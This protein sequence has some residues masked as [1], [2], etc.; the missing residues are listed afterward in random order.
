ML[1][2]TWLRFSEHL[3]RPVDVER[4]VPPE[5][6]Y[7][8]IHGCIRKGHDFEVDEWKVFDGPCNALHHEPRCLEQDKGFRKPVAL[9]LVLDFLF[10]Q[11]GECLVFVTLQKIALLQR[12]EGFIISR[13]PST[14]VTRL[15]GPTPEKMEPSHDHKEPV[16]HQPLYI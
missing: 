6:V 13:Y 4:L 12:M 9:P 16:G 3:N 5:N 11:H 7:H 14:V 1:R 10:G 15:F 8:E 2:R